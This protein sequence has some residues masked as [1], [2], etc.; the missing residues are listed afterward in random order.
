M[1]DTEYSILRL[2]WKIMI[3]QTDSKILVAFGQIFNPFY[4]KYE[5][6][7]GGKY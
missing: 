6:T 1:I 3:S 4:D 7:L 2:A 5:L